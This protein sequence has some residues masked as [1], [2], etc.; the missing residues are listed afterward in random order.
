MLDNDRL[1]TFVGGDAGTWK[2][3]QAMTITGAG[4][5]DVRRLN[6]VRG[7]VAA[8][9]PDARWMLCGITSNERYT[10]R[11]EKVRLSIDQPRLG[12]PEA[13]CAALIPIRKSAAW[14]SMTQDQRRAI[15]A[16][17]ANHIEI[18]LR[19][20]PAIARRLHH[21]RDLSVE[22]PFDFLTWFEYSP[23]DASLFDALVAELRASE[24]WTYVDRE[25]DLRLERDGA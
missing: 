12:R 2:V 6:V 25:I 19:Y 17:R 11:V 20:L 9:P 22:A 18:G 7:S 13:R 16:E 14:W 1:F 10:T 4:L 3:V 24:E 23:S 5:S 21:C 8:P 15:F